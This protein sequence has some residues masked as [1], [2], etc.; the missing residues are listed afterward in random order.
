MSGDKYTIREAVESDI[1]AIAP[2]LREADLQEI[3][4]LT[5]ELPL[6][7][8]L[9]SFQH[10]N[11]CRVGLVNDEYVCI[12]GVQRESLLGDRGLIW[13]LGTDLLPRHWI[14]FLKENGDEIEEITAN[15][16]YVENWCDARNKTTIRWLKWL[17]FEFADA[18]PH[19]IRG[20]PFYH[21]WKHC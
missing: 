5:D 2:L 12:Y 20:L 18:K 3:E 9:D 13:M 14:R 1:Y 7:G 21:F 15:T 10:S 6:K 11:V 17:G 19:G 8:L 16:S 4:A